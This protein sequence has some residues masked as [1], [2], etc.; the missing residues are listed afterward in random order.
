MKKSLLALAV[1]GAFAGTASAQSSVTLYGIADVG[2]QYNKQYSSTTKSQESVV[3]LNG[4][5]VAGNRWGLRGSEALGSGMSAIFTLESGF[6]IDTGN[7][8]QGNR[9]FGRQAWAGLATPFGSIVGGRIATF[10]SGT[11]SFDMVGA[12]D[13]FGTGWGINTLG[14]TF[15]S[16]NALRV[17]NALAYVSPTWAGFKFGA[18]YSFNFNG[19]EGSTSDL[20]TKV[21]GLGASYSWGPLYAA[22][23][24][25]IVEYP[26]LEANGAAIS[27]SPDDQT[28]LQLGLTWD[29]KF[30]KLYGA[31]ADQSKIRAALLSGG[32]SIA[33]PT[34]VGNWDNNAWMLGVTAPIGNFTLR[35]S[36][37][38]SDADNII[39]P[40]PTNPSQNVSFEPDYAV[41]GIGVDYKLSNRT[42]IYLGFGVRDAKGS[43]ASETTDRDQFAV[44]LNHRF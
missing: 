39:R 7:S 3:G 5:Y 21:T 17:D 30:L 43:L 15:I 19:Q 37:Q 44:G 27:P 2:L 35:A 20:S 29:F 26:T 1:L 9:L 31:W 23:T 24:Y 8:G 28:H 22:V 11:G 41:Y 13:P 42:L 14:S 18:A 40:N 34:G 10:S 36:Y 4:G 32:N 16:A 6:D 33:V 38:Y 12:L 25:D